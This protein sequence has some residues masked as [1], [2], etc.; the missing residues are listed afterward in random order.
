MERTGGLTRIDHVSAHGCW[1]LVRRA[2][3]PELAGAVL[4]LQGYAEAGGRPVLRAEL[5]SLKIPLILIFG[6]GFALASPDRAGGPRPL[7]RGFVAGLHER[8]ALVGSAGAARCVQVD[9]TPLGA[10]RV[11]GL[12]MDE[13]AGG[14]YELADVFG[15]EAARLEARLADTPDWGARLD[16]VE[17]ALARRLAASERRDRL[18]EAAWRAIAA[19]DGAVRVEALAGALGIGRKALAARFRRAVGLPPRSVARLVRFERAL[20]RMAAG[21]VATLAD[22]AAE[23]GYADQAHFN[24]DFRGYAG[25]SPRRL[26]ARM[27]PDGTG[28]MAG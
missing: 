25:E 26:M 24:R 22:L 27:L 4:G 11:L 6:P 9:L 1:T 15:P 21:R 10:W 19:G 3:R 20:A 7:A 2:P 17:A 14:V 18:V 23:C 8:A 13:L 16:L 12:D 28:V 5:P